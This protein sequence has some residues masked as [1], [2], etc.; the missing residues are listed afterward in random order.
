MHC[1]RIEN[2]NLDLIAVEGVGGASPAALACTICKNSHEDIITG[3]VAL[4]RF[5]CQCHK[6]LLPQTSSVWLINHEDMLVLWKAAS[7]DCHQG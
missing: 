1:M 4:K 6:L 2:E 3:N 7:V 5:T